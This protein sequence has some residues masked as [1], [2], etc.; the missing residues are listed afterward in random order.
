MVAPGGQLVLVPFR[1][2]LDPQ[3]A[4]GAPDGI[5]TLI[6]FAYTADIGGTR[7]HELTPQE[8][9]TMNTV[10]TNTLKQLVELL[11]PPP[12]VLGRPWLFWWLP[13]FAKREEREL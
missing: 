10:S 8:K 2:G 3:A 11:V 4:M 6:E 12:P 9:S 1:M 5:D 13:S 7:P